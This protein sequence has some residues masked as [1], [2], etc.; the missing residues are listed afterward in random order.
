MKQLLA[1][2]CLV[3]LLLVA[4]TIANAQCGIEISFQP[5]VRSLSRCVQAQEGKISLQEDRI[6]FLR[7]EID[8][9]KKFQL[10]H[11]NVIKRLQT[12]V[13]ELRGEVLLLRA[14]TEKSSK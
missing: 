6:K 1:I 10:I 13:F 3:V 11:E 12:T 14:K 7:E 9:L 8:D 4:P 5:D 2:R